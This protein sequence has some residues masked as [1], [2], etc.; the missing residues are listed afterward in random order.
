MRKWWLL[1]LMAFT[2]GSLGCLGMT[3]AK[4]ADDVARMTVEELKSRLGSADL[5]ILDVRREPDWDGSKT[6]IAGAIRE[7]AAAVE[8][9]AGSYAKGKTIVLYCA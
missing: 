9:W 5:V 3:K 1:L 8:K 2:L 4:A 6:K 7:N